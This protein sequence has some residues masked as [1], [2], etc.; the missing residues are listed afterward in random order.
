MVSWLVAAGFAL[1][2]IG[3]GALV[4]SNQSRPAQSVATLAPVTV[5]QPPIPKT[6]EVAVEVPVPDLAALDER[7]APGSSDEEVIGSAAGTAQRPSIWPAVERRLLELVRRHRSTIVFS[8]SRR[9][10]ERLTARLN[11]LAAEEAE[12]ADAMDLDSAVGADAPRTGRFP[13]E[14][15]GQS[16]VGGGAPPVVAKA[17]HGSMS[18]EQIIE[19]AHDH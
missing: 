3:G 4:V 15:V 12:E 5:V 14:A 2:V 16:G 1:A 19:M 6:V 13:A 7:P 9:L 17:H 10:A 18:R 11:E 8:N